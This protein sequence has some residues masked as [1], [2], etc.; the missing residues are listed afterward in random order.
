VRAVGRELVSR[1]A[2]GRLDDHQL[3]LHVLAA[4]VWVGGQLTLA[5]LVP[6][7]RSLSSDAAPDS[8]QA[9]QRDGVGRVCRSCRNGHLE[10]PPHPADWSSSYGT[11]LIVRLVVV[12]VSGIAAAL[13]ARARSGAGL[14][15]FGALSGL[16]AL[17]ALFLGVVLSE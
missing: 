5:A 1:R 12:A 11:T 9:L 6:G 3:F 13:H 4:T 8:G 2:A 17:G 10:H 7:L 15:A 16:S 14:A